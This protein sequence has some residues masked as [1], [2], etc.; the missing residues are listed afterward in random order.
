MLE[1]LQV[2]T[3][4]LVASAWAP[5]LA[6]ALELPGKMRMA[7]DTYF[8]AQGIYYPGF[9]IAGVSEPL[10]VVAT[11]SLLFFTPTG[12][13][14]FGLVLIALVSLIAV[15][16]IFWFAVQPVNR[17]WV[18]GQAMSRVGSS[19]FRLGPQ[20]PAERASDWTELRDRWEYSHLARAIFG[21]VS[22][23]A[24]LVSLVVGSE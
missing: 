15:N 9:T 11:A 16:A 23:L 10:A 18:E 13:L 24:L 4:L 20:S 19:F 1:T 12:T 14:A 17:F 5:A 3:V 7:K 8:A 2:L 22:F 6:H 21:S